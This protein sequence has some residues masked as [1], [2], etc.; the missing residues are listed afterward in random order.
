MDRTLGKGRFLA[1]LDREGWEYCARLTGHAVVAVAAVTDGEELILTEQYRPP[2]AAPVIELPA[3]LVGDEPGTENEAARTAAA[4]ELEEETGYRAG[5]LE[6]VG[7]GPSSAGL[8]SEIIHFFTARELTRV[9]PGGG[10]GNEDITV[11]TVALAEVDEWLAARVDDGCLIDPKV[12]AGLWWL[13][14]ER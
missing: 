8:S 6:W 14:V 12:Y 13:G 11:L 2:V 1:L 9:G 3:G 7:H 5:S 4:R 10:T